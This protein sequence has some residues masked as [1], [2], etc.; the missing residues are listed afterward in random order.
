MTRL[1]AVSGSLRRAS[2]NTAL[3]RAAI[4]LAPAGTAITLFDKLAS[5]PHFNPDIEHERPPAVD[6]WLCLLRDC[7]GIM[8]ACP[9]Y[10][11][12]VPG[13]FK[14]ALDWAVGCAEL[15]PKPVALINT[16]ARAVHAHAAL[17][18]I[19]TTMGWRVIAEAS[20][21]I[22][23]ANQHDSV[24]GISSDPALRALLVAAIEA[25]AR[26]TARE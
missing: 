11:H 6:E 1:L 5:L 12:G 3:L 9:E 22:A 24:T 8:I 19:L 18:E 15:A 20:P 14:N 23:V 16:S 2:V 7:D 4:A 25:L 13:A 17:V 21:V 10:A 26:A